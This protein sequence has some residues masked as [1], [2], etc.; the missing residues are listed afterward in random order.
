MLGR[1]PAVVPALVGQEP[2]RD[3]TQVL[4]D[5]RR[6]HRERVAVPLTPGL[7][8]PCQILVA[9]HVGRSVTGSPSGVTIPLDR[10]KANESGTWLI[11]TFLCGPRHLI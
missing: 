1:T 9:R 6:E 4:V 2:A 3:H 5:D 7:K 10:R 8:Q 11:G